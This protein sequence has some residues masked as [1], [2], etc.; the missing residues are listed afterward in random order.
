MKFLRSILSICLAFLVLVSSSSFMV[1]IHYCGGSVQNVALF[2]KAEPCAMEKSMPPCHKHMNTC[3]EDEAVIHE[4]VGFKSSFFQLQ[5]DAPVAIDADQPA[6]FIAE[7]I[8]AHADTQLE[9]YIYDP[10]LPSSDLTI[11][12]QVFRI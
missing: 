6:L 10:P 5:L 1:G 9:Y 4:G 8:P 3:C 11:D 7:I 2:T 12:H